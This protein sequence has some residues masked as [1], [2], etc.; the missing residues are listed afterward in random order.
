MRPIEDFDVEDN[1]SIGWDGAASACSSVSK[2]SRTVNGTL[3]SFLHLFKC[4]VPT[5]NDLTL[6]HSKR[7]GLAPAFIEDFAILEIALVID[8]C[9]GTMWNKATLTCD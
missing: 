1:V 9:L 4:V 3:I 6:S 5:L 2:L 7:E 8:R